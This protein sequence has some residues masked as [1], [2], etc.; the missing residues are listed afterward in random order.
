MGFLQKREIFL[1]SLSRTRGQRTPYY[2][3]NSKMFVNFFS[4]HFHYARKH[5]RIYV[6]GHY[7]FLEAHGFLLAWLSENCSHLG[8]DNVRGQLSVYIFAPSRR[9]CLFEHES[10]LLYQV[11][12]CISTIFYLTYTN[13]VMPPYLF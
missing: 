10:W 7:Q 8:M 3:T 13:L 11:L 6:L 12:F 9:Y 4:F 5:A 1:C 2:A